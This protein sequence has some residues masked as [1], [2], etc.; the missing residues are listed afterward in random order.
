[1]ITGKRVRLR[2]IE[3]EDIPTFVRW[4]NDREVTQYLLV[5]SPFSKAMEEQWFEGQLKRPPHEGQV[6]AIEAKIGKDWLH[7]GNTGI[8]QVDPVNRTGEFGILIGE[9]AY[10]NQ[11]YGGEATRLALK[12]G[13]DDLNLHRIFLRVYSTNSR[14]I[15]CYKGAGFVQEGVLRE[16]IYKNGVYIDEIIMGILKPEW[17]ELK[18]QGE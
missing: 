13:F 15:A 7:I 17:D 8:H 5:N 6:L 1:M 2:A 9:K 18:S 12:H 4:L 16:A 11:G 14:A 3:R 10:W